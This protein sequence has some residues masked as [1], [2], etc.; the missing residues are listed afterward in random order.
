MSHHVGTETMTK[1]STIFLISRIIHDVEAESQ[2][3]KFILAD[4]D[5]F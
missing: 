1:Y 4:S 2:V 3:Q 5:L